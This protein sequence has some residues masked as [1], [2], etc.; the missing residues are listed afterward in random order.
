MRDRSIRHVA[1]LLAILA[2]ASAGTALAD[3]ARFISPYPGITSAAHWRDYPSL[4]LGPASEYPAYDVIV[5]NEPDSFEWRGTTY[6]LPV[7]SPMYHYNFVR[8]PNGR[9]IFQWALSRTYSDGYD[10]IYFGINEPIRTD[11]GI[12]VFTALSLDLVGAAENRVSGNTT[13]RVAI[14]AGVE[15]GGQMHWVEISPYAYNNDWCTAVNLG[16]PD[17]LPSGTCDPDGR[18][19]R[20]SYFGGEMVFYTVPGRVG[21]FAPLVPGAGWT[22]Y[23][24]DWRTLIVSYPWTDPP[25]SWADARIVGVYVG[26]E[27]TG[28]TWTYVRMRDFT[29]FSLPA[30][31]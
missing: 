8:Q 4:R 10:S 26:L 17:G 5:V 11:A 24:I 16:N 3:S 7:S 12:D 27:A 30:T 22:P 29:S 20:R 21:N 25:D 14:G 23:L 15:W 28:H 2:L 9:H 1:T 31:P 19:D 18:Y 6:R 13:S